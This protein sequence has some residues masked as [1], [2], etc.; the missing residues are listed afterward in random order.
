MSIELNKIKELS[1]GILTLSAITI[2]VFLTWY[3]TVSR[4]TLFVLNLIQFESEPSD[5][6][7][8]VI[9]LI[10][11]FIVEAIGISIAYYLFPRYEKAI[12]LLFIS[13]FLLWLLITRYQNG[14]EWPFWYTPVLAVEHLIIP[15]IVRIG[16]KKYFIAFKSKL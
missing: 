1:K 9:D 6:L 16:F 8:C 3:F 14:D 2:I 15:L 12:T 4:S 5:S 7:I 11:T 10:V 13:V